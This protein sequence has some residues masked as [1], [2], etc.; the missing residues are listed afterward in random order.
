VNIQNRTP[1]SSFLLMLLL[2][3]ARTEDKKELTVQDR[4][5]PPWTEPNSE[6]LVAIG[7]T[8]AANNIGGCGEYYAR[9][10]SQ[11]K[12]EF[13]VGC[14]SDGIT[15]TYSIVMPLISKVAGPMT[16]TTVTATAP[17][18]TNKLLLAKTTS[19]GRHFRCLFL[20]FGLPT[21]P[22]ARGRSQSV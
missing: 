17:T 13:L 10:S 14:T 22:I 3:C 8:L 19:H 7:Q 4:Y 6:Q 15:W 21:R 18:M 1:F 11:D 5:P 20:Y 2:S 9:P 12:Y 16:D